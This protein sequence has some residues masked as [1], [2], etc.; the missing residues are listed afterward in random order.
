MI[1]PLGWGGACQIDI[2]PDREPGVAPDADRVAGVES[3]ARGPVERQ[4]EAAGDA[5][6]GGAAH[7]LEDEVHLEAVSGGDGL[8]DRRIDPVDR[9][10][11]VLAYVKPLY[12]SHLLTLMGFEIFSD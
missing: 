7:T 9:R 12:L 5:T 3:V 8:G 6:G 2:V 10:V 4:D 1:P 11:D